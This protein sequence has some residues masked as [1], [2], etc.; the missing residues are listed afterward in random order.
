MYSLY[1]TDEFSA[2]Y[3]SLR[4]NL[5]HRRLLARLRRAQLGSLGDVRSVGE[6]V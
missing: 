1:F 6:C 3:S 2:W 4:D 5:T